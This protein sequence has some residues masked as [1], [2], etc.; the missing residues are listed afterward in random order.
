MPHQTEPAIFSRAYSPPLA[1]GKRFFLHGFWDFILRNSYRTVQTNVKGYALFRV[2]SGAGCLRVG[3]VQRSLKS[4]MIVAVSAGSVAEF[5]P[6]PG[7][8]LHIAEILLDFQ[9]G[10][11]TLQDH[12]AIR[13]SLAAHLLTPLPASTEMY[14]AWNALRSE[15]NSMEVFQESVLE[16][17]L[18]Q[19]LI[20]LYRTCLAEEKPAAVSGKAAQERVNEVIQYIDRNI[21][22]LK[23]V[24]RVSEA[25]SYNYSYLSHVFSAVTGRSLRDYFLQKR[26]EKAIELLRDNLSIAEVSAMLGYAAVHSFS[27][28]FSRQVGRPPGSFQKK[29][30]LPVHHTVL[31]QS[32]DDFEGPLLEWEIDQVYGSMK[33][34]EL[35]SYP[36]HSGQRSLAMEYNVVSDWRVDRYSRYRKDLS[37]RGMKYFSFWA[38]A[39]SPVRVEVVILDSHQREFVKLV[40]VGNVGAVVCIPLEEFL[41]RNGTWPI[42][43]KNGVGVI[44]FF[45]GIQNTAKPS[46]GRLFIDDVAFVDTDISTLTESSSRTD[47]IELHK[48]KSPFLQPPAVIVRP[49]S[50]SEL[51]E[52]C[53]GAE[54]PTGVQLVLRED[55]AVYSVFGRPMGTL[56]GVFVKIYQ[57]II[58][59]LT[60][61]DRKTVDQL[62]DYL[63]E[64]NFQDVFI[65]SKQEDLIRYVHE[66]NCILRGILDRTEEAGNPDELSALCNA[67]G[68][69]VLLL[70][71]DVPGSLVSELENRQTTVW[72]QQAFQEKELAVRFHRMLTSGAMGMI[73][74]RADA[75]RCVMSV[76]EDQTQLHTPR[77]LAYGYDNLYFWNSM[78]AAEAAADVHAD[79]IVLDVFMTKDRQFVAISEREIEHSSCDLSGNIED[80]TWEELRHIRFNR[81]AKL[82]HKGSRLT[83][84]TDFFQALAY[85]DI[86]LYLVVYEDDAWVIDMLRDLVREAGM[87]RRVVYVVGGTAQIQNI[88]H[89]IP[90]AA[91]LNR[92]LYDSPQN[93]KLSLPEILMNVQLYNTGF[94]SR[95]Q[96][97]E[98]FFTT[99]YALWCRGIPIQPYYFDNWE[100]LIAFFLGGAAGMVT[101]QAERMNSWMRALLSAEEVI[102]LTAGQTREIGAEMLTYGGR[103]E[104]V[105]P[106]I[107]ILEGQLKADGNRLTAEKAGK[108][109][110][111]L[112]YTFEIE[113]GL[114]Y[115][116]YTQPVPVVS[117]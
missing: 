82:R 22:Y 52:L 69:R 106:E 26:F 70:G 73:V 41:P 68:I 104:R 20:Y 11:D 15:L 2:A 14:S 101:N 28:A 99:M 74:D 116:K 89:K 1:V 115:R 113:D 86:R 21:L 25:L 96:R 93:T 61:S 72:L 40:D 105:R 55:L 56:S 75:L 37:V 87:E 33:T 8:A 54:H 95:Y 90:G 66:Q 36:R 3:E 111:M 77:L 100:D 94:M 6:E 78:E 50:Q 62:L 53:Q 9:E 38:K 108:G 10:L 59:V 19:I 83:R 13:E 42:N 92:G 71:E 7:D 107:Q 17:L 63:N 91:I 58:P 35:V 24:Y 16:L 51:N 76:Y 4:G 48:K 81:D 45:R 102:H 65:L 32:F 49:R 67:C 64:K 112:W 23:N 110:V 29:S 12:A 57:K 18:R 97:T 60:V 47:L 46:I 98:A 30:A 85:R 5:V 114:Y 79:G 109:Y 44:F 43:L 103:R 84:L 27:R 117:E 80:Y 34:L 31:K 39:T 88:R